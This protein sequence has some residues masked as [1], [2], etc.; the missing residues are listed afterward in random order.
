M[1]IPGSTPPLIQEML[2]NSEGLEGH[3]A[4][5]M[6]GG[7]GGRVKGET[8]R[9]K[10]QS[11]RHRRNQSPLQPRALHPVR[12]LLPL[13]PPEVIGSAYFHT[14][15]PPFGRVWYCKKTTNT[16]DSEQIKN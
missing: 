14:G 13:T 6:K 2:E 8:K 4:V 5:G 10:N 9:R 12:P 7:G 1:E 15:P 3:E 16:A 11:H